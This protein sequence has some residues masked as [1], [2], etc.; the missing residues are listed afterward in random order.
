M[1]PQIINVNDVQLVPRPT[2][3]AAKGPAAE[4]FDASTGHISGRLGARLLG[5]NVTTIP[6][7]KR[8]FPFHNHRVNEEMFFILEG[9]GEIRLGEN[10][11]PIRAGDIIACPPGG[12]QSAHQIINTGNIEL[13]FLAVSTQL[14]DIS[15]YP[16]SGKFGVY[17]ELRSSAGAQ[18]Q[19]FRYIGREELNV[20]YWDGE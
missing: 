19:V 10:R 14:P 1:H 17:M 16:D 20:D 4:R 15:E 9:T 2:V 8:A 7:G 11:H 12:K 5:Y 18:P 13:K 3:Y 6:P